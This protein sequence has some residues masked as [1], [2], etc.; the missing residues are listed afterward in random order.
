MPSGVKVPVVWKWVNCESVRRAVKEGK[1]V[2]PTDPDEVV[3]VD[4][5]ENDLI[6]HADGRIKYCIPELME[7]EVE[8]AC[9]DITEYVKP[10]LEGNE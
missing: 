6:T 3:I 5:D 9:Y 8:H 2:H 1:D 7:G 4:Y 10:C